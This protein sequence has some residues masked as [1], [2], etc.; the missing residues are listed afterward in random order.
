METP[1]IR[2]RSGRPFC[3]GILV[4]LFLPF[5]ATA[6]ERLPLSRI[7]EIKE[8]PLA[9]TASAVPVR[10]RAT[11]TYRDGSHFT[12]Q[13]DSGGIFVELALARAR[14][15]WQGDDTEVDRLQAGSL[16]DMEALTDRGGYAPMLLPR[17]LRILGQ[18]ELPRSEPME[19]SRFFSGA[20]NSRRVEARGV[21]QEARVGARTK[22]HLDANPGRFLL[23]VPNKTLPG[24]AALVDAE[25][26]ITGVAHA[27]F[28]SRG[29]FLMPILRIVRAEDIVVEKPP[30]AAPFDLPLTPLAEISTFR[31]EPRG[32]HRVRVEGVVTYH[33]PGRVLYVQDGRTGLRV[34]ARTRQG[35][36]VGDRVTVA[37]FVDETQLIRSLK[38]AVVRTL[39]RADVAEALEISPDAILTQQNPGTSL[40]R[41][42]DV[43]GDFN[44]RLISFQARLIEVQTSPSGDHTLYFGTE[45]NTI[46]ARLKAPAALDPAAV[47][48]GSQLRITGI[49]QL[50][51]DSADIIEASQLPTSVEILLRTPQDL[52]VLQAP[53]W[54][55]VHRAVE[56]L[57][58]VAGALILALLW[59]WQL[60]RRVRAQAVTLAE[61]MQT[62]RNSELEFAAAQRERQQLAADLHDGLQQIVVGAAFR[63]EA[64]EAY[65]HEA[66]P[67]L[68]IQLRAARAAVRRTLEALRQSVQSLREVDGD[69]QEFSKLIERMASGI[70]HWQPG[71][72]RVLTEGNPFHLT[73]QSMGSLL[74]L[75]QEA[76]ANAFSHG[77][78]TRVTV[79][80]RYSTSELVVRVVDD[81]Q[82]FDPE[83]APSAADGHFGL[84]SIRHRA[85]WL[86]GSVEFRSAPG[87]GTSIVIRLPRKQVESE[88]QLTSDQA[89]LP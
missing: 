82:G 47:Q 80:L 11:V 20:Q 74:M 38:G 34:E 36:V 6:Q 27:R 3:V 65:E 85:R 30:P 1:T 86:G 28:N 83:A 41:L 39:G 17:T 75:I 19:P 76:T 67:A 9:E 10:L 14:K 44:G 15:V 43:P 87:N 56:V 23:D 7:A 46:L 68:R 77:Q 73:R 33:E 57:A 62:H 71:A 35:C 2:L 5:A 69:E 49:A 70:D 66:A 48:P 42:R 72:V 50:G 25:V 40:P 29:E 84:E 89:A 58:L 88:S 8:L 45:Q 81:G 64:A 16:I 79:H 78:A 32:G 18:A 52:C 54:L 22:L 63:L 21:V 4:G 53:S 59:G 26:R 12:I 51:F 31:P 60:R 24:A 61:A 37:G 13:D 55:T